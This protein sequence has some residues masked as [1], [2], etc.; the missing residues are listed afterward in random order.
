MFLLAEVLLAGVI[1][2]GVLL[3]AEERMV[4]VV[5]ELLKK[6][7]MIPPGLATLEEE[8]ALLFSDA[9]LVFWYSWSHSSL[10]GWTGGHRQSYFWSLP[11]C[12]CV[13]TTM[14]VL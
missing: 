5:S 2:F 12:Q 4:L 10:V 1:L 11:M 7:E 9:S 6:R 13:D 14:K 8:E 3:I